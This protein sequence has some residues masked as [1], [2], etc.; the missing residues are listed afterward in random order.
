MEKFK[1]NSD[2]WRPPGQAAANPRA[3]RTGPGL[4]HAARTGPG[5]AH[6]AV[7]P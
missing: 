6:V 2:S 7:W 3:A 1:K 4:A 5:L